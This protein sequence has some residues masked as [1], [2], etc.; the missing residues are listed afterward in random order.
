MAG[1]AGVDGCGRW[2]HCMWC[3]GRRGGRGLIPRTILSA[4]ATMYA[5]F[6]ASGSKR[7]RVRELVVIVRV[8]RADATVVVV[9]VGVGVVVDAAVDRRVREG[10]CS[11][12]AE[13]IGWSGPGECVSACA[14]VCVMTTI[15]TELH[16]EGISIL[17]LCE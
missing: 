2:W 12:C 14:R 17:I 8:G 4:V 16:S 1:V 9:V 13:W 11:I 7:I 6:I 10:A 5:A 15:K 3:G